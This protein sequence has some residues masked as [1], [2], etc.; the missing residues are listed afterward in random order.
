MPFLYVSDHDFQGF[1][2]FFNLKYGSRNM[3]FLSQTQT[4]RQLEWVGPTTKDLDV[5]AE[6]RSHFY[7]QDQAQNH[8]EWTEDEKEQVRLRWLAKRQDTTKKY[9]TE[10]KGC[11]PN[12]KQDKALMKYWRDFGMLEKEP[13]VAKEVLEMEGSKHGVSTNRHQELSPCI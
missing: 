8:L 6:A 9:I 7:I 1:Q 13:E 5:V 3:G 10:G 11:Q 4:C 2:I 12:K